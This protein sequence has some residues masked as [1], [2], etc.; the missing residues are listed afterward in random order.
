[1]MLSPTATESVF[2]SNDTGEEIPRS[3]LAEYLSDTGGYANQGLK[4]PVR[5]IT[6]RVENIVAVVTAGE[7]LVVTN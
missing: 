4:D 6:P 1:M 3:D 5:I 7:T 2:V